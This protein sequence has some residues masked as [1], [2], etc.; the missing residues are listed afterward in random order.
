MD[1]VKWLERIVVSKSP[2]PRN[3][4]EYVEL[5]S[6]SLKGLDRR[7]LPR[8]LVKSVIVSPTK[9]S[10]VYRGLTPIRGL[11]WSGEGEISNVE[12]SA[13]GG[14]H[15]R[16]AKRPPSRGYE[17]ISWQATIELNKRGIVEL[18]CRASDAQGHTQPDQRDPT[19][20]DGY[21][22]NWYHRVQVVVV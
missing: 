18:I 2:L 16:N 11:A 20:L 17:W 8:I 13:D 10:V 15:W 14:A 22:Q 7:S 19:R 4:Q 6:T 5:R 3:E 12:I 1:S 21:G 9:R